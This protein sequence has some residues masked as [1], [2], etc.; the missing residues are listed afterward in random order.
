MTIVR[1]PLAPIA[2]ALALLLAACGGAPAAAPAAEA[3]A[4]EVATEAPATEAAEATEAPQTAEEAPAAEAPAEGATEA[5]AAQ[6][7]SGQ[8]TFVIVPEESQA[9]YIA[10]EEFFAD[11]LEKYG[12]NAGFGEAVG[13]TQAIEGQ[14]TLNFDD[15]SNALG[16]NSFTVQMNT[17]ETG[18][19]NRDTWIREN[20]P[21]F[22]D[23]PIATF[24]GTAIEGAP[25]AYTEGEEVS[26]RLVGDLTVREVTRPTTF[27]V[28][29]KLEGDTLTGTATTA[30]KLTDFSIEP[31]S[32]A[33]TLTVDDD[34]GIEVQFTAREQ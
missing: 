21:R 31:P 14:L 6:S 30:A 11:A 27:D 19:N 18:R 20:G 4:A 33:N 3:P 29:A 2:L 28:T 16:E 10:T 22:N 12:I 17:L 8:R 23:Y 7:L 25:A 32:F 9:S 15:L 1:T 5:A 13:T 34:F 26:F 24:V